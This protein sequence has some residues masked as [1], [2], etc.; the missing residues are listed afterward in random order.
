MLGRGALGNVCGDLFHFRMDA[1]FEAMSFDPKLVRLTVEA[2]YD[3]AG[4]RTSRTPQRCPTN[5]GRT[6]KIFESAASNRREVIAADR[7]AE[8]RATVT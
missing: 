1:S 7:H 2:S 8:L 3:A 6:P 5:A 4:S